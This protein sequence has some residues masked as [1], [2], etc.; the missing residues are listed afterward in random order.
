LGIPRA[1]KGAMASIR[2]RLVRVAPEL[3]VRTVL[4]ALAV[5]FLQGVLVGF[6][7]FRIPGLV[8]LAAAAALWVPM[9]IGL[10]AR[11]GDAAFV[12]WPIPT[13]RQ[14]IRNWAAALWTTPVVLLPLF[15]LVLPYE[16]SLLLDHW[17]VYLLFFGLPFAAAAALYVYAARV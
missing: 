11:A 3:A 1:M 4:I 15:W 5:L 2:N 16:P 7:D 10:Y 9:A 14:K 12:P 8:W 17:D 6:L 13:R